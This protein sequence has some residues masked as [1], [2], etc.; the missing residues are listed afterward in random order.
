VGAQAG[1]GLDD[2]S[3]SPTGDEVGEPEPMANWKSSW[4]LALG[5]GFCAQGGPSGL[6]WGERD[7]REENRQGASR[8]GE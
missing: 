8:G 4:P 2:F 6:S 7:P 1:V 5:F 3:G